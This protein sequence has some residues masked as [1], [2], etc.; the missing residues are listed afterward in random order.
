ME[1]KLDFDWLKTQKLFLATPMYGGQCFG[2]YAR[3]IAETVVLFAQH[4]IQ[5]HL[6]TLFNESLITRARTY[7]CDEFLRSDSTHLLFIDS[8]VGF[9]A[10]DVLVMMALTQQDVQYDILG[11]PY[12]KKCIAYEKIKMA[13]DKGFADKDP[14]QLEHFIGDFVF[15]PLPGTQSF[16]VSEPSEMLELGTGFMMIKRQVLLDFAAAYPEL[17][18]KPDHVR[19]EHFDGSREITLFFQ[20]E[21]DKANL[22]KVY[23]SALETL[24]TDGTI[25]NVTDYIDDVLKKAEVE[26]A[27]YSKRYLSEDYWFCQMARKI[28]KKIWL[29]PWMQTTHTGSHVFGGSVAAMGALGA[30]ATADVNMLGKNKTN[31]VEPKPNRSERRRSKKK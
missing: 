1:I 25:K 22:E 28:G 16:N 18:Y 9:N 8:D 5:L 11:A 29:L 20:A 19:T 21:I 10:Q 27:K 4:G 30:S 3:S 7:A 15:N 14:Q 23:R 31:A 26:A 17:K 13:V 2:T 12:P 6:Y 24:R